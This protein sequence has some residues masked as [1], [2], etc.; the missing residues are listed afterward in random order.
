MAFFDTCIWIELCCS[1]TPTKPAQ[2]SQAKRASDLLSDMKAKGETILTCKEQLLE[3]ISAIL[4]VKLKE[5]QNECKKNAIPN[6]GNLKQYRQRPDFTS[7][8]L[9]CKQ[10]IQDVCQMAKTVS[11]APYEVGDILDNIHLVDINDFL[12]YQYCIKE[13]IEFYSFDGDFNQLETSA[14]IHII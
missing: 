8:Q 13:N 11:I 14:N 6:V 5:Y 10:A 3:I 4:K 1:T 12:Y 2:K 9:L 7:A